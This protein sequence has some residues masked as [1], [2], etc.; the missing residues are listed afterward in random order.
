MKFKAN[1]WGSFE[2]LKNDSSS[3][4][5]NGEL[6]PR[7]AFDM[8]SDDEEDETELVEILTSE[9]EEPTVQIPAQNQVQEAVPR[10]LN[11]N[12]SSNR[13]HQ[14]DFVSQNSYFQVQSQQQITYISAQQI[15]GPTMLDF[16]EVNNP[17]ILGLQDLSLYERRQAELDTFSYN[18]L[19]D[20][21][22]CINSRGSQFM[23]S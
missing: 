3:S 4:T 1:P 9:N 13:S 19:P 17:A 5:I 7:P 15:D 21:W 16:Q 11:N 22:R 14:Q 10:P 20:Y 12:F 23:N 18:N 8:Y 2:P 6:K